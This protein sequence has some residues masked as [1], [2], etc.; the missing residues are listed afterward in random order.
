[1]VDSPAAKFAVCPRMYRFVPFQ[2]DPRSHELR[3]DGVRVKIPE[4]CFI[5]LLTLLDRPGELVTREELR[6]A[7]WPSD[8][9]V[10]F[11]IG[12]NKIVR[13]LRQIL[14]DSADLPTFIETA[15]KLG[16]RFIGALD[17]PAGTPETK[18][19]EQ[20]RRLGP[21]AKAKW[22]AAAL[23]FAT[24]VTA[25]L[26]LFLKPSHVPLAGAEIV[27][28]TGI[29]GGQDDPAFSP[30]GNQVAFTVYDSDGRAGIYTTI[31]GA[32]KPLQLTSR[33]SIWEDCCAA[34]STDGKS[35]AFAR[36]SNGEHAVYVIPALGG[37]PR[38]IYT[39]SGY[40]AGTAGET[41]SVS[42]S[43]DGNILAVSAAPPSSTVPS[44]ILLSLSDSSQR[45]LTSPPASYSDWSPAFS[46]DGHWVAFRRTAGPG[47]VD[48][49]YVVPPR[50]GEPRRLTSD[51]VYIANAPAWTPDSREIIFTS[52]RAGLT[53]LWRVPATGGPPRRIEG[54][55][56]SAYAP[57]VALKGHRL[58]Y[59]S[60]FANQNLWTVD[61]ADKAHAA[62]APHMTLSSKGQ[63]A[64]PHFSA[65]GKK[66]A[67]E[68]TRSGY[69]EIWTANRD[70]SNPLQLTFLNGDSGTPRWSYDGR[71]VAFD[72]RPQEHSEV[73]V[74]DIF[75][76]PPRQVSTN[77]GADNFVPSW[78]RDG[79]WIYFASTGGN[80]SSQIWKISYPSGTPVQLT[81]RGGTAP[82][83]A[84]DG[85]VYFSRSM[86]SDEVWKIPSQGGEETLVMKGAG[87]D[88]WC[89]LALGSKGI[90]FIA[91]QGPGTRAFFYYDFVSRKTSLLVAVGKFAGNP[92]LSP[93]GK[94]MIYAQ[95][96]V[97][98]QT[99]LLVNNFR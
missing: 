14:G 20:P 71:Y 79:K 72:S 64:L 83:E 34:W 98:D 8:T 62:G 16:Y 12:L 51:N 68:S 56:T 52:N 99:I 21:R 22:A 73:F 6:K 87:L 38:K 61:L 35:I 78:S 57:A 24:A 31:I 67:F 46:P 47:L 49:L 60:A 18:T 25:V 27:P 3:R 63:N 85:F 29:S 41:R 45:V 42:W 59:T 37:T 32:E 58:A 54:I 69:N 50:G 94:S 90:Y 55:G 77:P 97:V 89:D 66:I 40:E 48:D 5:V 86:W 92:S 88:C 4:Q 28:L 15:P 93:D 1:V 2:L 70:G 39:F 9:F 65:D 23:F 19:H 33:K 84:A 17:Q 82:I 30:D 11:D 44:I 74:A 36:K 75:G 53:T 76:S 91:G 10:D 13:Q 7:V 80:G 95:T 43:P 81:T 96:D 26:F